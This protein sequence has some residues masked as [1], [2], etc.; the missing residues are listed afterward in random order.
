MRS[1]W[2]GFCSAIL[3]ALLFTAQTWAATDGAC[4]RRISVQDVYAI[5]LAKNSIFFHPTAHHPNEKN[6]VLADDNKPWRNT[7]IADIDMTQTP[8]FS[9]VPTTP[10]ALAVAGTNVYRHDNLL[11]RD[12]FNWVAVSANAPW[13]SSILTNAGIT[14]R[15]SSKTITVWSVVSARN[16]VYFSS[17]ARDTSYVANTWVDISDNTP[18]GSAVISDVD[19][20]S[21][22][23]A[24]VLAGGTLYVHKKPYNVA[25]ADW[26]VADPESQ[27]LI[28]GA[29]RFDGDFRPGIVSRS[30]DV[31]YHKAPWHIPFAWFSVSDNKPWGS[32]VIDDVSVFFF[33][34]EEPWDTP[35]IATLVAGDVPYMHIK[36]ENIASGD[37]FDI[38]DNAPWFAVGNVCEPPPDCSIASANPA[39]IWP[40]NHKGVPVGILDVTDAYGDP[41]EI[42]VN[43]IFQDEKVSSTGS[44]SGNTSPDAWL[45]PLK[46]RAER[47]GNKKTPGN[48]RVYHI[49]F[50]ADN[51]NGGTCSGEVEVCV[52]HDKGGSSDCV[53][54]GPLYNSLI[55]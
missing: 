29:Q 54:E 20:I 31:F 34:Q 16:R 15:A 24:Y 8:G 10:R 40:P 27:T 19:I 13:G 26:E 51:G 46:V 18:W 37:W 4:L 3:G 38:S 7:A 22:A 47:N 52:P 25:G 32:V 39:Y 21:Q 35:A 14:H 1:M 43:G 53:D 12:L 49:S 5:I 48:G 28:R 9:A 30:T 45:S 55:P 33:S 2:S 50:T 11:R 42:T 23:Y 44:G 36:P 17:T 41:V 6:W